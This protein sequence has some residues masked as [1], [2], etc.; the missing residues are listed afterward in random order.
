MSKEL[1]F[2]HVLVVKAFAVV[3]ALVPGLAGAM[4]SLIFVDNALSKRGRLV[5]VAGGFLAASFLGPFFVDLVRIWWKDAP[6][7]LRSA[8]IF[9]TGMS[10][11]VWIPPL[12]V[13]MA[14][15]AADPLGLVQRLR[16]GLIAPAAK[17]GGS[18]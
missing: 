2:E 3:A 5:T 10:A 4:A 17:E 8:V 7:T 11:I 15:N 12:L 16:P 6:E 18:E 14:K 9:G 1:F 13:W